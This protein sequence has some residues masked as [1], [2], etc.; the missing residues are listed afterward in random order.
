MSGFGQKALAGS[1]FAYWGENFPLSVA[2][3]YPG[4]QIDAVGQS[5]WVEIWI[6]AWQRDPRRSAGKE[7]VDVSVTVHCFVEP[8]LEKGRMLELADAAKAT[9]EHQQV[10]VTD[11]SSSDAPVVGHLQLFETQTRTMTRQDRDA[12]RHGL[13]HVVLTTVG[14]ATEL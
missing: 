11:Q 7:Q 12:G 3:V 1:L 5:E 13:Q 2:T 10:P 9:L 4:T 6:N 14:L 8:T